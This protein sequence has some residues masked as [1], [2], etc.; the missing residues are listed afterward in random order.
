MK[1]IKLTSL[2]ASFAIMASNVHA[3]PLVG[4]LTFN[5]SAELINGGLT[6]GTVI[7]ANDNFTDADAIKFSSVTA[8]GASGDFGVGDSVFASGQPPVFDADALFL[9]PLSNTSF[10]DFAF[11]P[12]TGQVNEGDAS[13]NLA[14]NPFELWTVTNTG[15][16]ASH[17]NKSAR[18][19]ITQLLVDTFDEDEL[20][21]T[22]VGTIYS[23]GYDPT[24]GIWNFTMQPPGADVIDYSTYTSSYEFTFSA[25]TDALGPASG[26]T[27][28]VVP[29][30]SSVALMGLAF[31]GLAIVGHRKRFSNRR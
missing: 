5:G 6:N 13:G 12:A 16:P 23:D 28:A 17:L 2:I 15:Q 20:S 8:I 4:S 11:G 27:G 19:E 31:L 21:L 10:N 24:S 18:F 30:P 25:A 22:G 29:E 26:D 14:S 3:A 7:G 1:K 9:G